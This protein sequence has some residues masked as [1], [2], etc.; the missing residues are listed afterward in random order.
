AASTPRSH[1]KLTESS[2]S[3]LPGSLALNSSKVCHS[4]SGEVNSSKVANLVKA[5]VDKY[6]HFDCAPPSEPLRVMWLLSHCLETI[7]LFS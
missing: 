2:R 7:R 3:R 5:Y 6:K 1:G 4:K